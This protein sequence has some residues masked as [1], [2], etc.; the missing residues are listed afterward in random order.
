MSILSGP[1]NAV[2]YVLLILDEM[3]F[4]LAYNVSNI[5][6]FI[7]Q[8]LPTSILYISNVAR[9]QGSG[10]KKTSVKRDDFFFFF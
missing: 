6:L 3:K 1:G 10:K 8:I 2:E 9:G 5:I 7:T 4:V